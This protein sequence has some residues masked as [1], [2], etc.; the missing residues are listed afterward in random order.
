MQ[1]QYKIWAVKTGRKMSKDI[2]DPNKW[3]T[4]AWKTQYET[5]Q[6]QELEDSNIRAV[7]IY[8]FNAKSGSLQASIS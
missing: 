8:K 1:Q 2:K 6:R 3:N 4:T 7:I 5:A